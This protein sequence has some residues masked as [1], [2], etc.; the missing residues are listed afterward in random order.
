MSCLLIPLLLLLLLASAAA[1]ADGPWRTKYVL[2]CRPPSLP[3]PR[4]SLACAESMWCWLSVGGFSC[5][6]LLSKR[7]AAAKAKARAAVSHPG[8]T[9]TFSTTAERKAQ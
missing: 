5:P 4:P 6:L 7:P 3:V 8:A 2:V 1:G 9:A